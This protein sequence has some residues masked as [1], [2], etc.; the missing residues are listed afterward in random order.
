MEYRSD[1]FDDGKHR[2][3][4]LVFKTAGELVAGVIIHNNTI[5]GQILNPKDRDVID[6]EGDMPERHSH[7]KIQGINYV[8]VLFPEPDSVEGFLGRVSIT[9]CSTDMLRYLLD[10]RD[11]EQHRRDFQRGKDGPDLN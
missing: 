2:G 8:T 11:R 7:T 10:W 4:A 5:I 9:K 3:K 6:Y 1:K